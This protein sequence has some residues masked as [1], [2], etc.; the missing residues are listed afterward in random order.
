METIVLSGGDLG[1]SERD[2]KGWAIGED[3]AFDGLV[4]RRVS[5]T[6]AVLAGEEK[7]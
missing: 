1:G 5:E 3:R 2:A 4:Y 7:P 6:Q